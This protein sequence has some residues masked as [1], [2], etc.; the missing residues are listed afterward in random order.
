MRSPTDKQRV[1]YPILA[2]T[3]FSVLYNCILAYINHNI[4]PL[5]V[6]HVVLCEGLMMISSV[7]FILKKGIYEEDLPI[8]LFLVFTLVITIY[9][10]VF[11]RLTFIDQFRNILIIFCFAGI[12]SWASE[13]TVRLAFRI[14]CAAVLLFLVC[15]VVSTPFYV[16]LFHPGE[17]FENTR[18][19]KQASFN[20]TGLF[21]NA[22]GFQGRFSFGLIDHRSS[23][24]FL[25]Q[26]SLANFCGVI[27]IYL[28]SFWPKL[29]LL[30]KALFIS[31]VLLILL[32]ND[33]RTMLIFSCISIAGY[34]LF[35]KIPKGFSLIL[36]PVIILVG[37]FVHFMKPDEVGDNFTGRIGVTIKKMLE[38]DIQSMLGLSISRIGEFADSGYV[39]LI[40]G[41][42][43]FG[44]IVFWLFVCLYPAGR[45]AAQRRCAHSLSLFIFL[46]MMIGGTA[47]FSIKIAGLLWLLVG[48]M[49]VSDRPRAVRAQSETLNESRVPG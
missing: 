18:G 2:I 40:Y 24:I 3:L 48:Y 14:A 46:N 39:Y 13:R 23:S 29:A 11:N 36:M 32:T 45:T 43:I 25:E 30:E 15:E 5:S 34:F 8:V 47:I 19:I 16:S 6:S 21:A 7:A 17:Y 33:T 12:G 35:P 37:F 27:V 38:L 10:T 22:L 31:T 4:M 28:L 44:L 9:I 26:V 49:R 42:T 41:S 20:S 1:D